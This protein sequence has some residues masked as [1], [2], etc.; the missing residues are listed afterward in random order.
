VVQCYSVSCLSQQWATEVSDFS[1]TLPAE[2]QT[3]FFQTH[4]QVETVWRSSYLAGS[5][6]N[7]HLNSWKLS[8]KHTTTIYAQYKTNSFNHCSAQLQQQWS[9]SHT[10]QINQKLHNIPT[11]PSCLKY[12]YQF[13]F[14]GAYFTANICKTIIDFLMLHHVFL[15]N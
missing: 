2:T 3:E 4:T 6:H 15:W 1:R 8:R 13:W 11:N 5:T 14:K 7:T 9:Y 10:Q 12:T